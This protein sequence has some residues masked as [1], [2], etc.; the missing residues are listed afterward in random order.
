MKTDP[1]TQ[2]ME[3]KSAA[4]GPILETILENLT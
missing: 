3:Y 1:I 2:I 4:L